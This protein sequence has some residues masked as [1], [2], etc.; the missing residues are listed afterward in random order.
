MLI[1]WMRFSDELPT[2]TNAHFSCFISKQNGG[3]FK[4]WPLS[5]EGQDQ[6]HTGS[7]RKL[8]FSNGSEGGARVLSQS[9]TS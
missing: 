2:M 6:S 5:T 4:D 3:A 9:Q 8:S 1:M 7:I